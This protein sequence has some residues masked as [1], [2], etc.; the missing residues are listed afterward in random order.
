MEKSIS[1]VMAIMK[2]VY[3]SLLS[4]L[5]AG[6]GAIPRPENFYGSEALLD[7]Y[8][9]DAQYFIDAFTLPSERLT[10]KGSASDV[11]RTLNA[12][13]QTGKNFQFAFCCTT[14]TSFTIS[15]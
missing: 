12:T 4:A 15:L 2:I 7:G 14:C 11:T 8:C 1:D 6:D 5:V 13:N 3:L 10:V 9:D